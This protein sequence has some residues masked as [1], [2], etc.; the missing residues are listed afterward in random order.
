MRTRIG[1]SR[2]PNTGATMT[3]PAMRKNGHTLTRE[4]ACRAAL[5]VTFERDL[6]AQPISDGM[7]LISD[8]E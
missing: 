1:T 5:R 6:H 8:S 4:L 7:L 3:T 2:A